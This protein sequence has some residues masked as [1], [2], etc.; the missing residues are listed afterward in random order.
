MNLIFTSLIYCLVFFILTVKELI[1]DRYDHDIDQFMYFGSRLLH[2]ELIWTTEFDDKSPIVQYIFSLPALFKTTSIFALLTLLISIISAYLG[3]LMLKDIVENSKFTIKRKTKNSILYFGTILYLTLLV[4]IYGSFHHIN[5]ISASLCLITI[6]LS[7]INRNKNNYHFNHIAAITAAISI[8]IRPYYLLNI[9]VIPLWLR[10]R[11]GQSITRQTPSTKNKPLSSYIKSQLTWTIIL[12]FYILLLNITPYLFTGNLS[13]FIY[14]IKINSIDY[15]NH[16]IFERQY[17]NIGRNPV[18]YPI[19]LGMTI[20][21]LIRIIFR[22]AIYNYYLK[23]DKGLINLYKLDTDII[24]F[25]I[26]GPILLEIMFYRKHFF[27]H[28]FTLFSPYILIS[29][30]LLISIIA[31]L[32][33]EIHN[34]RIIK[35]IIKNIFFILLIVCLVTNQNI[36]KITS[37]LFNNSISSK[38][39]KA[40]LIKEFIDQE[41][42]KS[43]ELDFLAPENNYLHWK[44]DESRHGFPQKAVYINIAKGKMDELIDKNKNLNYKFLLPNKDKLCETLNINA[45]KY[46]ITQMNDYSFIC[47]SQRSS[48]YKLLTTTQKLN[49]NNIFIFKRIYK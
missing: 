24:F 37:E 15:V 4:S 46:I 8:S 32:N 17:I 40:K 49:K 12:V 16:N 5:A 6:T 33:K 48:N 3:Y 22:K 13:D 23:I 30:V 27:G 29:M 45:P 35:N 21:P 39:Y 19:I 14:G 36:P 1:T 2:G 11:E 9:I 7:Y 34:Y 28:Y 38:S 44:L 42:K 18:L 41:S 31:Q 10:I 20:L 43:V 25:G 47:L 26:I